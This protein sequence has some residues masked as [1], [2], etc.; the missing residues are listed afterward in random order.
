MSDDELKAIEERA[1]AATPGPWIWEEE[2]RHG[3]AMPRLLGGGGRV[4]DFGDATPYENSSG[5]EPGDNDK[6]FIAAARS[7]IPALVAEVRRLRD[8][9]KRARELHHNLPQLDEYDQ[10][11]LDAL[12][13]VLQDM[14]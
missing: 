14:R 8:L 6:A 2:D 4:C 1:N 13:A 11:C 7:D 3:F 5:A 12:R 10:E 9:G